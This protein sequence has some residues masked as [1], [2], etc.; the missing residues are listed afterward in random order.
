L[1]GFVEGREL[2]LGCLVPSVGGGLCQ[3]SGAIYQ[4]ALAAGATVVER[5]AHTAIIPDSPTPPD[6][7]ATIFW[8]YVDLR[9][10]H[11]RDLILRVYLTRDDLVVELGEPAP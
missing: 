5:H 1:R 8:N 6:H 4:C 3:L 10:R 2:R 9:F 7:D 11:E